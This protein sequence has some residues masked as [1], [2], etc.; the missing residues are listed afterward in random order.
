MEKMEM[1]DD[2]VQLENSL[3][4][5]AKKIEHAIEKQDYF[6]AA[7]HK[8]QEEAIK[9]QMK[10]MRMQNTLPEHLRP[11]ITKEDVGVVLAEKIGV[12]SDHVTA[13]E[14]EK[15]RR[16]ETGLSGQVLGQ[17][18]AVKS[19]VHAMKRNRL[20]VIQKNKPIASFIF[21]GPS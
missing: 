1:N 14:I 8:Q 16:L 4:T 2:Y 6:A 21:M 18:D 19:V 15:L 11:T 20:S 10:Q 12:P 5:L 3:A 9:A 17:D 13:S 7:N